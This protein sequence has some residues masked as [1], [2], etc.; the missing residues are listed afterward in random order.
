MA[1]DYPRQT[2]RYMAVVCWE[3]LKNFEILRGR[4]GVGR[5]CVWIGGEVERFNHPVGTGR[6]P[7]AYNNSSCF[8]G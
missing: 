2:T 6:N 8:I 1:S 4:V 3:N 7:T 5:T